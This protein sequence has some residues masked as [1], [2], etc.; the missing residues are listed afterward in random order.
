[1]IA[2]IISTCMLS[3]PG[4]CR[5]QTIPLLSEVST[6]RCTMMAPPHVAKWNEEHPQWRVVRWRC[7]AAGR[8]D[9]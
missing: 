2:I 7:R 4:I 1:M 6:V 9:I 3:D 5:E 8:R